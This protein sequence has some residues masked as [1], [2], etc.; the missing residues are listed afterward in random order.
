MKHDEAIEPHLSNACVYYARPRRRSLGKSVSRHA[1]RAS[2]CLDSLR[3]FSRGASAGGA[4]EKLCICAV[5]GSSGRPLLSPGMLAARR[6]GVSGVS[7]DVDS[8]RRSSS[9]AHCGAVR[10]SGSGCRA[11]SSSVTRL[12]RA[13][14]QLVPVVNDSQSKTASTPESG[15]QPADQQNNFKLGQKSISRFERRTRRLLTYC[16]VLQRE[17]NLRS[18]G[19]SRIIREIR[20]HGSKG[21]DGVWHVR[22]SRTRAHGVALA[23]RWWRCAGVVR[24]GT[25]PSA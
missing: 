6:V 2:Q 22:V 9:Q 23:C 21:G 11:G 3:W 20:A 15:P 7:P 16:T 25:L 5:W 10:G 18:A 19:C 4:N 13:V 17:R 24:K 1:L 14:V 12:G 8:R